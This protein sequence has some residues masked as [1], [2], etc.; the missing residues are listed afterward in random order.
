MRTFRSHEEAL[1]VFGMTNQLLESDLNRVERDFG[2]DLGRK[3]VRQQDRDDDYYP[4]FEESIRKEAARMGDHYEIFYC[5]E[6]TIRSFVSNTL[7]AEA[8]ATWWDSGKIPPAIHQEVQQRIQRELD[9]GMT[10]RSTEPIDYT[11]FGELAEI[12]KLNWDLLGGV[13]GSKKAVEKVL[14]SL[15]TLRGP[16][17]H[18]SVLAEDE[19]LRLQLSMRDWFRLME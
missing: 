2:I 14:A 4:Q 12:I 18:C 6:K 8:G 19:V 16:I 1:K 10:L 3:S 17:A 15:N 7:K 5:L 9:S 11:T 13:L